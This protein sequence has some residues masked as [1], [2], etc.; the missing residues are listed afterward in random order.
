MDRMQ[1]NKQLAAAA[2]RIADDLSDNHGQN[3]SPDRD[4]ER[5]AGSSPTD[6]G[7]DSE[8]TLAAVVR[9]PV[10][11]IDNCSYAGAAVIRHHDVG[12][13][14]GTFT[15][16]AASHPDV[17]L[18]D[19]L[20]HKL[21]EGPLIEL[22]HDDVVMSGTVDTDNRWPTWGHQVHEQHRIRSAMAFRLFTDGRTLAALTLYSEVP[23]AFTR[24]DM[25]DA[26][27]LAGQAGITLAAALELDHMH[28][29][30][31]SR[32]VIGQA[33]GIVR[34]RFALREDQ[35]FDVL[36]RLSSQQNVKL[37]H[38]AGQIVDTGDLPGGTA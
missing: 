37:T 19:E 6:L 5:D 24:D 25:V 16:H 32:H 26:L 12:R 4:R 1:F 35:A 8:N 30:L 21:G 33:V 22:R 9:L 31:R 17:E 2:R 28:A 20:Q 7:T 34:E 27:A 3:R 14:A 36:K 10:D 29:A 18:I 23:D 38:I 13:G 15:S 11:L